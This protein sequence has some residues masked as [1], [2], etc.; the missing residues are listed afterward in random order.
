MWN[1]I[2]KR[3]PFS[4]V[5]TALEKKCGF[6]P[7]NVSERETNISIILNILFPLF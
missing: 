7:Q 6:E 2:Y 4:V 5:S 3:L 1:A